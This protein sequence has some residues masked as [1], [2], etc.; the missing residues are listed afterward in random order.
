MQGCRG[1]DSCQVTSNGC[2]MLFCHQNTKTRSYTRPGAFVTDVL[3]RD[4]LLVLYR[5]ILFR[6]SDRFR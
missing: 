2:R 6:P 4:D 5:M 3:A 1:C